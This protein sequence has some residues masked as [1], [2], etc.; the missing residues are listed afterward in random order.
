MGPNSYMLKAYERL[1]AKE[2]TPEVEE[3]LKYVSHATQGQ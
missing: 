1:W 2:L 3:M